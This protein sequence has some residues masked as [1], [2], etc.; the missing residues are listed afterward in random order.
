MSTH[1]RDDNRLA[2]N[3]SEQREWQLL[4]Q[5]V[6]LHAVEHPDS[7]DALHWSVEVSWQR[8]ECAQVAQ[9]LEELPAEKWQEISP[10]RVNYLRTRRVR[11]CLRLHRVSDADRIVREYYEETGE[12]FQLLLV[13]ATQGRT[14]EFLRL[15]AERNEDRDNVQNL[16][17]DDDIGP[18]LIQEPFRDFRRQYPRPL[19]LLTHK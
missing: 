10:W 6:D 7:T 1:W 8:E 17:D 3:F 9:L 4:P 14:D 12:A 5:L 16:Y 2:W 18:I 11:S 15:A 19:T 13:L